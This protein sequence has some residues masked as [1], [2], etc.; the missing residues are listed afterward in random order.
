MS[1]QCHEKKH[2]DINRCIIS[3]ATN[4]TA[5]WN[6]QET[7][8]NSRSWYSFY[9]PTEGGRLSRPRH[10]SKG[11]QPMPKAVYHSGCRDKHNCP[12]EL[13]LQP[14]SQ[15]S[16]NDE[17]IVK[18]NNTGVGVP[19]YKG[20]P[21]PPIDCI[22]ALLVVWS[23]RGKIIRTVLCCVVYYDSSAQWYAHTREQF[24]HF[25]H[26][27]FWF[28]L[29]V[30]LGFVFCVFFHVSLGHFVRVLLAFVV[31]GLVSSV[32]SQESGWEECL[33]NDLFCVEWDV[34]P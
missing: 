6:L 19:A 14:A 16:I 28:F 3:I 25:L 22:W 18:F 26:V 12:M 17:S 23:I 32:L 31:L 15:M 2:N 20:A 4:A 5:P 27:R 10:C 7:W 21:L 30:Y 1:S 9:R 34:K 13:V 33:R 8:Q 24:L 29:S 11:V